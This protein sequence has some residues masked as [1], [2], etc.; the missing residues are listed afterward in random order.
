MSSVRSVRKRERRFYRILFSVFFVML[1]LIAAGLVYLWH[2]LADYQSCLPS[3]QA[4]KAVEAYKNCDASRLEKWCS[5]LPAEMQ[6]AAVFKKYLQGI[7]DSSDVFYYEDSAS[8]S[9][10]KVYKIQSGHTRLATLTVRPYG[11][12]DRFGQLRY[13]ITDLKQEPLRTYTIVAPGSASVQL[14]GSPIPQQY[15]IK[16]DTVTDEFSTVSMPQIETY[17]YSIGGLAC[18]NTLTAAGCSEKETASDSYELSYVMDADE[19]KALTD[20]AENFVKAYTVF[21]V[22]KGASEYK[23]KVL[24]AIMPDTDLYNS[25]S[26][27]ANDWGQTYDSDEYRNLSVAELTKYN[28][29]AYSCKVTVKYATIY[30]K[31]EKT[32]DFAFVFYIV[33]QNGSMKII[34]M[35]SLS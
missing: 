16:K 18:V 31:N 4:E 17:T 28:E 34:K 14:N 29:N 3:L 1:L 26:Q 33:K 22:K 25:V 6:D 11:E 30:K 27:Y 9:I 12:K 23:D 5:N 10:T 15:I 2:Y 19:T 32:Y 24:A 7:Y 35:E 13:K 21:S 8:E 20:F